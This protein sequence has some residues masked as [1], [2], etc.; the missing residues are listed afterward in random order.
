MAAGIPSFWEMPAG[1]GLKRALLASLWGASPTTLALADQRGSD[2][3]NTSPAYCACCLQS[4]WHDLPSVGSAL[5]HSMWLKLSETCTA[6][7]NTCLYT[8][9]WEK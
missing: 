9:I 2:L 5:S 7:A 1:R 8:E 3:L 4:H 6:C